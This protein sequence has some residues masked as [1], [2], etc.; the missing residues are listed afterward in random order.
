MPVLNGW[1]FCT[2]VRDHEDYKDIP[3]IMITTRA[4]E[5]DLKKGEILGVSAYLA[6][7]FA[8][9]YLK[10][11]RRWMQFLMLEIRKSRKL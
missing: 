9:G 4:T 11:C 8:Q 6:K 7:P 5:M 1:E 3:I 10:S 2:E